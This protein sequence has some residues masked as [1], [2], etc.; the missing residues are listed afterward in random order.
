MHFFR[1]NV[2]D[3]YVVLGCLYFLQ[4]M[5]YPAGFINRTIQ[6]V[7]MIWALIVA[8]RYIINFKNTHPLLNAVSLLVGM[9]TIYGVLLMLYSS[10]V[11]ISE[12]GSREVGSYLYLQNALNSLLPF[13]LLYSFAEQGKLTARR[14]GI[15]CFIFFILFIA[16]YFRT[17][18]DLLLQAAIAGIERKEFTNNTG[19]YFV[20]LIP[21]LFFVK[22]KLFRYVML[23]AIM[24]FAVFCMKRGALL[25][26]GICSL[27][28]LWADFKMSEN[29]KQKTWTIILS[30]CAL[31][32]VLLY[33]GY[34]QDNSEYFRSRI[35]QT[36]KGDA[37]GRNMIYPKI[38]NAIVNDESIVHLLIGR[39]ADS[40][41]GIAGN[42]AHQD[43]LELACN[44]GLLGIFLA[45]N[46]Y[47]TI[48]LTA[49]S[50]RKNLPKEYYYAF[51]ILGFMLFSKT[52]FS[53]SIANMKIWEIMPLAFLLWK[54][55]NSEANETA[56]IKEL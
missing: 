50:N 19:Y 30:V 1:T 8:V 13:Y 23:I 39:G 22:N 11:H 52:M 9:Y 56:Q 14:I 40:T 27:W 34:K 5:L 33:I 17:Y 43:W 47:V 46:F 51:L 35:E 25:I 15:Y 41:V 31:S 38:W 16:F 21:F 20:S 48:F 45:L 53:M 28:F 54:V 3:L 24:A 10:D 12:G 37:S 29:L 2:C 36:Q 4:D 55:K 42:Y 44:N 32:A 7:M 18:K 49:Y 6:M 26:G